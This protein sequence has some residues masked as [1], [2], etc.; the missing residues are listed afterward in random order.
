M[1]LNHER[2]WPCFMQK[3]HGAGEWSWA[4][5]LALQFTSLW[6]WRGYLASLCFIFLPLKL[7]NK[8]NNLIGLLWWPRDFTHEWVILSRLIHG[9][10]ELIA[11]ISVTDDWVESE[12]EKRE[13]RGGK[14]NDREKQ[15]RNYQA[16]QNLAK[17]EKHRSS[18]RRVGYGSF[19]LWT[20][21]QL[22]GTE[23]WRSG[24]RVTAER[25]GQNGGKEG[26]NEEKK[27][28]NNEIRWAERQEQL[29]TFFLHFGFKRGSWR[30]KV[31]YLLKQN[32]FTTFQ[33]EAVVNSRHINAWVN[34][35]EIRS[36]GRALV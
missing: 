14:I 10:G 25:W 2:P 27:G 34:I 33:E 17:K 6:A 21:G 35:E 16:L 29:K 7:G 1:L 20:L 26:Q 30:Q 24:K 15:W 18:W 23:L 5:I 9:E 13:E 36:M 4:C 8:N 28:Q 19:V 32:C 3:Q 22:L 11:I 31:R 12:Q